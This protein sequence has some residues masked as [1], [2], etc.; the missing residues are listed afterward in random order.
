MNEIKIFKML[1]FLKK[2]LFFFP[3]YTC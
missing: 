1:S 3:Q 2:K